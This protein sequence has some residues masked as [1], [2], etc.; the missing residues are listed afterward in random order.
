V[1]GL[2]PRLLM[3]IS[4]SPVDINGVAADLKFTSPHKVELKTLSAAGEP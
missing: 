3:K 4:T 2:Q 1:R